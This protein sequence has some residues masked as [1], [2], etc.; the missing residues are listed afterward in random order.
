MS[1]LF[2]YP[3]FNAYLCDNKLK[4]YKYDNHSQS[5]IRFR[6]QVPHGG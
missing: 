5:H 1:Q 2:V 3:V 6:V 4:T